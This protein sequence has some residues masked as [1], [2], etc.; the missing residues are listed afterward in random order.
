MTILFSQP[1]WKL[2]RFRYILDHYGSYEAIRKAGRYDYR[3]GV[4]VLPLPPHVRDA[5]ESDPLCHPPPP[6]VP[7]WKRILRAWGWI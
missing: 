3:E 1:E 4:T 6:P 2:R 7:L 5:I